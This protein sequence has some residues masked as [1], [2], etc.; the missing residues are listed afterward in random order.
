[1]KRRIDFVIVGAQKSGTTALHAFL[2][3]H[4]D[5][6]MPDSKEM[7]FFNRTAWADFHLPLWKRRKLALYHRRFPHFPDPSFTYGEATP[8]YMTWNVA[9]DRIRTYNPNVRIIALLRHP[10]DRAYSH[11]NMERQRDLVQDSFDQAVHQELREATAVGERLDKVNSFLRRGFYAPQI[12][13]LW[14]RFG[15][16]QVLVLKHADLLLKHDE[17]LARAFDFLGVPPVSVPSKSVHGRSYSSN[18]SPSI[19]TDLLQMYLGD[20]LEVEHLLGWDCADWK[21]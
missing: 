17:T 18:M 12:Q 11:W 9:L 19:R 1:M 5:I 14:N 21:V 13:A 2:N 3:A 10:V 6:S 20:V 8:H 16:G 15:Q 7:H 4:P